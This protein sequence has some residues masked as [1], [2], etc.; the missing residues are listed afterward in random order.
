M[1]IIHDQMMKKGLQKYGLH[2]EG[3][4]SWPGSDNTKIG[5]SSAAMF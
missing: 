3:V 5:Y 2:K 4:L 1:T